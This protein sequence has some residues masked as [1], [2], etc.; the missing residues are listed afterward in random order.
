MNDN[1]D[2]RDELAKIL[3][4]FSPNYTQTLQRLG[5]TQVELLP[6]RLAIHFAFLVPVAYLLAFYDHW[7]SGDSAGI[8]L[9]AFSVVSI[10]AAVLGYRSLGKLERSI[11]A[12]KSAADKGDRRFLGVK[13]VFVPIEAPAFSD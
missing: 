3:E 10:I 12:W 8:A 7:L 9:A 1:D 11:G 4:T 6:I 2:A 5:V 13:W